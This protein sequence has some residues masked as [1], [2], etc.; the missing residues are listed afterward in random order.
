MGTGTWGEI[1]IPVES[2]SHN[3]GACLDWQR[4]FSARRAEG[5]ERISMVTLDLTLS[6]L[7]CHDDLPRLAS[8]LQGATG[9]KR[10]NREHGLRLIEGSSRV[11][12]N[13]LWAFRL[14]RGGTVPALAWWAVSLPV[15]MTVFR[16]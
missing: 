13:K 14:Y 15:K 7:D 4:F 12:R 10:Q 1:T 9:M 3:P 11:V 5:L 8:I 6:L 16:S 2:G